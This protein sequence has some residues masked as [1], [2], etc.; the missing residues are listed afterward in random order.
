MSWAFIALAVTGVG[1]LSSAKAASDARKDAQE[2][3]AKEEEE[4]KKLEKKE[5]DI[6]KQ[7]AMALR[8]RRGATPGRGTTRGDVL[9]SPLGLAGSRL[10]GAPKTLIG[11]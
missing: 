8:K 4:A 3:A 9:T 1:A 11:R 10:A 2:A 5:A 6:A 7:S